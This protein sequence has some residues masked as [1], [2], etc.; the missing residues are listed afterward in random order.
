MKRLLPLILAFGVSGLGGLG[1]LVGV[2]AVSATP[3]LFLSAGLVVFVGASIALVVL[4]TRRWPDRTRRRRRAILIG[5]T[6][7]IIGFT[8]TVVVPP[9]EP[10]LPPEPVAGQA[11]VLLPTGSRIAYVRR[12]ATTRE[13]AEPI[14]FLHGGPGVP[15]LAGDT[16]YFGQLTRDGHDVYVYAHIGSGASARLADPAEYTMDRHLAD[17]EAFRRHIGADQVTLI[18]H[19]FGASLAAAYVA[20]HPSRVVKAVY[21]SPG[22]L[23]PAAGGASLTPRLSLGRKLQVYAYLMRPRDLLAYTLV[24]VNPKAAHT[25]TG[26]ADMDARF[27]AHYNRTRS[28]LRCDGRPGPEL[29]GLGAYANLYPQSAVRSRAR[30]RRADLARAGVPGLVI[31]G[32]CDYLSWSSAIG[33][34]DVLR[35]GRLVYLRGAGHNAYQERPN[36]FL[37]TVRAFLADDPLP[38]RPYQGRQQPPEFE[39]PA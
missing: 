16:A 22:D 18:G 30:D 28:A 8:F 26:D 15:D 37:A 39:G 31:K 34:L 38:V 5:T 1:A 19:S 21:S 6:A 13:H 10:A 25:L 36:A 33:Y 35:K 20:D 2:A 23:D 12:P 24:Q 17:L 32:S 27:D 14:I 29:H 4:V 9:A 3:A 11:S 7:G